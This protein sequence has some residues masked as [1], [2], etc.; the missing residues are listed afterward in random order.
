MYRLRLSD[1]PPFSRAELELVAYPFGRSC[2]RPTYGRQ[3]RLF[4]YSG[5][6]VSLRPAART[7]RARH[8]DEA[9]AKSGLQVGFGEV[10]AVCQAQS[11]HELYPAHFPL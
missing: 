7:V 2:V 4:P 8:L 11:V 5:Q 6:T 1:A 3:P 10:F 9:P